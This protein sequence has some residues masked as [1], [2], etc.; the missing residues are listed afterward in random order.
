MNPSNFPNPTTSGSSQPNVGSIP[1]ES[2]TP[3]AAS[4]AQA[5]RDTVSKLKTTASE[6]ASQA[7]NKAGQ[8][9]TEK[10]DEAAARV[11]SYGN[12]IHESARSL[13]EQDPNIAWLTH[14]AA[15]RLQSLASYVRDRDFQAIRMD[16]E[17]MAR[18]HPAAFFGGM[19]VAGFILG[20]V[21]KASQRKLNE[22]STDD[23]EGV[24]AGSSSYDPDRYEQGQE[25]M[26]D[27]PS[28]PAAG[29]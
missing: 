26:A 13:E 29:I 14:R 25:N 8:L 11:D 24:G 9:A 21:V 2:T 1:G 10:K 15:D 28:A 7:A 6:T 5:A 16:A 17:N 18:R 12:A 4:V 20:S 27:A 19:C 22:P 3:T 23:Y